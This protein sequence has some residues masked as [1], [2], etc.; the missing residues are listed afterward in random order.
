MADVVA[1]A[2]REY[3]AELDAFVRAR[4]A[5]QDV[6]DTLQVAALRAIERADSLDDPE[7]VLAWLQ[8]RAA[9]MGEWEP[10][11]LAGDWA[12]VEV[13]VTYGGKERGIVEEDYAIARRAFE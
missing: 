10:P 4:V 11:E 12:L 8:K 2:L 3:H 13:M 6:D 7:R 1:V 5:P 9:E